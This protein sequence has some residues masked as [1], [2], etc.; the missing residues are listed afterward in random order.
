[1][2]NFVSF[3]FKYYKHSNRNTLSHNTRKH[4]NTGGWRDDLTHQNFTEGSTERLYERAYERVTEAKGKAI[5]S[6]A[7]TFIDGVL[8][9]SAERVDHLISEY[10]FEKTKDYMK[11]QIKAYMRSIQSEFGFE[12]VSYDF[13]MDEGHYDKLSGEWKPNYHAHLVFFNYD[14]KTGKAPLRKMM[15]KSGRQ[16]TSKMQ[17][18]AGVAFK[19]GGFVRGE[20]SEKNHL[21]KDEWIAKKQAEMEAKINYAMEYLSN[22]YSEANDIYERIDD[23]IDEYKANQIEAIDMLVN[24]KGRSIEADQEL[25]NILI[26]IQKLDDSAQTAIQEALKHLPDELN[27]RL[28]QSI[29]D[30][31]LR[32]GLKASN[33]NA[34]PQ[35]LVNI[36]EL[37]EK[38]PK[39]IDMP[40]L[41]M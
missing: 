12:P 24:S 25:T 3:N 16:Q 23:E 37:K 18:L 20:P 19:G 8:A 39:T 22:V 11:K 7:N 2:K 27:K 40:R 1:M 13:H 28:Y 35:S 26:E 9:F 33:I 6:N 29:T 32:S 15:G 36:K 30:T 31:V 10:G 41:R 38:L 21:E 4:K 34:L 17:D 5:Q 14:F